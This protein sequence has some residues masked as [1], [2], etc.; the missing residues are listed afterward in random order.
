LGGFGGLIEVLLVQCA[1]GTL[2]TPKGY[3]KAQSALVGARLDL[4]RIARVKSTPTG[5]VGIPSSKLKIVFELRKLIKV[6]F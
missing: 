6:I 2:A 3:Q 5:L 4:Y 1:A